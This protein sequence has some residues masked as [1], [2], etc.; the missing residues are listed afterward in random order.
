MTLEAVTLMSSGEQSRK[1][2]SLLDAMV[3]LLSEA[4][5][6]VILQPDAGLSFSRRS[7]R[8]LSLLA[9]TLHDSAENGEMTHVAFPL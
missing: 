6:T 3:T 4:E 8:P 1:D 9:S 5:F 7:V 2:S